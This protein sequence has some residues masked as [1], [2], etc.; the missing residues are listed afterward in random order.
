MN[1]DH[2]TSL[3]RPFPWPDGPALITAY[4]TLV[5]A[6]TADDAT[7]KKLG[8]PSKLPR[9][10]DPAS[11]TDR[12]LRIELWQWLE[13]FVTWF[14]H[15]YVWDHT[16]G[17]IIPICWPQ[18]PHLVHEIAVLA[19]QRRRAGLDLTSSTLEDWHR[20]CV[21]NFLDRLKARTSSLCDEG[22]ASWPAHGRYQRHTGRQATHDRISLYGQDANNQPD[23]ADAP[24]P[25]RTGT[26]PRLHLVDPE[27]THIDP[28]TGEIM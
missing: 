23:H 26:P 12:H 28:S 4:N 15:E 8:D 1:G 6:S 13:Q 16:S 24:E 2:D 14:N 27:G 10:W 21:P 20:Y 11:C 18:H 3:I 25:D 17:G 9:P 22:H 5:A 19:D 7:K